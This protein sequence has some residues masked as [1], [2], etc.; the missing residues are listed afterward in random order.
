MF[1]NFYQIYPHMQ[2]KSATCLL[3][4]RINYINIIIMH[5]LY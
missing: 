1:S 3:H 5:G 4:N 2:V